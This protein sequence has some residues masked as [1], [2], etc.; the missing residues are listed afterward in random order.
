MP[1]SPPP[2]APS[3]QLL[4]PFD[5]PSS[6]LP[7]PLPASTIS[8]RQVWRSLAPDLQATVRHALLHVAQEVLRETLP[9]REDHQPAP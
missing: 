9:S 8:T 5:P 4:L 6:P 7:P 3:R 1:L 2:P